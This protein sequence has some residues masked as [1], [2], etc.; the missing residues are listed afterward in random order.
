MGQMNRSTKPLLPFSYT[1]S[2]EIHLPC[3]EI[4]LPALPVKFY[5]PGTGRLVL[6]LPRAGTTAARKTSS[7]LQ[8]FQEHLIQ[9][10]NSHHTSWQ[11]V[12]RELELHQIRDG[13]Q[14]FLEGTDLHLYCPQASQTTPDMMLLEEGTWKR[15]PPSTL[16]PG[17]SLRILLRIQGLSFQLLPNSAT[18]KGKYR[19]QHRIL[20]MMLEPAAA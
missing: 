9:C 11:F 6:S 14:S 8:S 18:W 3:L 15:G 10:V 16:A 1:V 19:L 5:E 12:D 13:F 17:T 2:P 7:K 4:L 20:A